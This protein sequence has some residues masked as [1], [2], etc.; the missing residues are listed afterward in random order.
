MVEVAGRFLREQPE[1]P[2][3]GDQLLP[4]RAGLF[5]VRKTHRP[6]DLPRPHD[7]RHLTLRLPDD[8]VRLP[9]RVRDVFERGKEL[10]AD[11]R[12]R[13]QIRERLA[14]GHGGGVGRE[15]FLVVIERPPERLRGLLVPTVRQEDSADGFLVLGQRRVSV[16]ERL[17]RVT[18]GEHVSGVAVNLQGGR[19]VA[20]GD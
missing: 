15:E 7:P 9:G 6:G 4:V 17:G 1:L 13:T 19:P 10:V 8:L 14:L 2:P 20:P 11:G 18:L 12:E 5:V 3:D 16:R